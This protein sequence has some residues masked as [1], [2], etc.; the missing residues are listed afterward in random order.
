M[1]VSYSLPY[2]RRGFIL[3]LLLNCCPIAWTYEIFVRTNT[4]HSPR[5]ELLPIKSNNGR[6]DGER[7]KLKEDNTEHSQERAR[8]RQVLN[9]EG[10]AGVGDQIGRRGRGKQ[11]RAAAAARN[12]EQQHQRIDLTRDTHANNHGDHDIRTSR[13][14]GEDAHHDHNQRDQQHHHILLI[15][16]E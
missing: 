5:G 12:R 16:Y 1:R 14:G 6:E 2:K 4:P 11:E 7:I 10:L 15:M 9:R 8:N 3:T 13:I